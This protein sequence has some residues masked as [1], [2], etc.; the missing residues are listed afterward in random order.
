MGMAASQVAATDPGRLPESLPGPTGWE[1]DITFFV[2]C[3]NEEENITDTLDT[4]TAALA[5]SER[6]W[7]V[8]VVDD[9]SSD[10]S[11]AII[12]RYIQEHP[13]LPIYCKVNEKNKGLA[14]SYIDAAFLGRGKY[15]RLVCG[16]NA[17]PEETFVTLMKHLGEADMIIP[18][19]VECKGKS[20]SRR[21]LSNTYTWMVNTITG[22][23]IRYY[24]GLAVHLRYN[25]MRWHTNSQGFGFQADMITRLLDEGFSYVEVPVVARERVKG[26]AKAINW[27]NFFSVGHTLLEL[28]IRRVARATRRRK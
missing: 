17:E 11:A 13:G 27:R 10:R 23:R 4:L 1:C 8:I 9:G 28:V 16:D 6:S 21:M 26:Q 19:Q 3:Y 2:A 7:E 22:R 25:V 12:R 15:Y 24:N 20:L 5:G 18:Y 14:Q